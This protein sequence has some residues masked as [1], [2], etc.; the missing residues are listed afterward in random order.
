MQT[1]FNAGMRHV[2]PTSGARDELCAVDATAVKRSYA[3]SM[4]EFV[5]MNP[6]MS[7][8]VI[9]DGCH[10][11]PELLEFAFRMKGR[12]STLSRH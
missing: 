4:A 11:A 5:L 10:L 1:A 9:A 3:A 6:E 7:T 12:K 8:E 2:G